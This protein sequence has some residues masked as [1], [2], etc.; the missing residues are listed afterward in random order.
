MKNKFIK[1]FS[2]VF[3]TLLLFVLVACDGPLKKTHYTLTYSVS[4]NGYIECIYESGQTLE[5]NTYINLIAKGNG[6]F[7]GW[8]ENDE[9]Y[10]EGND[11]LILLNRD[12]NLVAKFSGTNY[13]DDTYTLI[14]DLKAEETHKVCA[15]VVAV[16]ERGYLLKDSSGYVM[17]YLGS[18]A[19]ID[20]K[21]NDLV[22]I[23]GVVEDYEGRPQFT[24]TSSISKV[25]VS[26]ESLSALEVDVNYLE[27]YLNNIEYGKYVTFN[28]SISTSVSGGKT[29]YNLYPFGSDLCIYTY[30]PQTSYISAFNTKNCTIT[31]FLWTMVSRTYLVISEICEYEG[32]VE[33]DSKTLK[34]LANDSFKDV[35]VSFSGGPKKEMTLENGYYEIEIPTRAEKVKFYSG[36]ESTVEFMFDTE[37]NVFVL[38]EK[39]F[40]GKYT[41]YFTT[42]ANVS[43]EVKKVTSLSMNDVHGYI[44]QDNN[45]KGGIS[46]AAYIVNKIRNE[47]TD[48]DV[49]LL[50]NG[51]M[52][53]G[54]AVSNLTKG[55]AFVD[56][57]SQ[58]E[59]DFMGIGNHEYDWGIEYIFQYFDGDQSNGEATF[60][61]VNSNI[62]Y[63]DDG[64][65]VIIDGNNMFES[66]ILE[67]NGLKIGVISCIGDVYGSIL[68]SRVSDYMFQSTVKV[69]EQ[70]A[71]KLKDQGADLILVNIHDGNSSGVNAYNPNKQ[72]AQMQYNGKNLIDIV[73]NGHTHTKQ[74]GYI[75]RDGAD[76][77]VIQCGG[78]GQN[79]G[80]IELYYDTVKEELVSSYATHYEIYSVAGTN[81]DE[82]V[83]A[84]IDSHYNSVKHIIDEVYCV[85]GESITN[86]A[87]LYEWSANVMLS[88]VGADIGISNNGGLRGTGGIYEGNNITL[89]NLY[90]INPFDNQIILVEVPGYVIANFLKNSSIYYDIKDGLSISQIQSDSDKYKVAV[91]DYVFYNYYSF[92]SQYESVNT[93]VI[94]REIMIEDL[95]LRDVFRPSTENT[96]L[97]GQIYHEGR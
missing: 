42:S 84:I 71:K 92:P 70:L 28:A 11:L 6:S 82:E 15:S 65:L 14:K 64:K 19:Q 93:E 1:L 57:M 33:N 90:E 85:A 89:E 53:Q 46:N 62:V 48:D 23:S 35:T 91:I 41:G 29:Y 54:T 7:Q 36:S 95:R 76:M 43:N 44:M 12:I 51:D 52:F 20:Y 80:E 10:D 30:Y 4:G 5:A 21:V 26:K 79:L 27:S 55:L 75:E 49:I 86:T 78:N 50:A 3:F 32:V 66:L 67:K 77:P 59:F 45:G 88:A 96:A 73:I 63:S 60:P 8:Y 83:E 94:F 87:Q 72:L 97:I 40:Q 13:K 61:L 69:T 81:Y 22:V 34:V 31:G 47:N 9:L 2:L 16:H 38:G 39:N 37:H 18:N 56:A 25:D 74:L 24:K 58:M 17:V 68:Q